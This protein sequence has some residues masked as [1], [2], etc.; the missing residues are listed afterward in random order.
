MGRNNLLPFLFNFY[1]IFFII[2]S[3]EFQFR[4]LQ[5]NSNHFGKVQAKTFQY[6]P[7]SLHIEKSKHDEHAPKTASGVASI[8]MVISKSKLPVDGHGI[9]ESVTE[10][11]D[12]LFSAN[13]GLISSS[14]NE[15]PSSVTISLDSNLESMPSKPFTFPQ[16]S[17][18]EGFHMLMENMVSD[19][20][21]TSDVPIY[22]IKFQYEGENKR[23]QVGRHEIQAIAQLSENGTES[24]QRNTQDALENSHFNAQTHLYKA[25]YVVEDVDECSFSR[26]HPWH[27]KCGRGSICVNTIGSYECICPQE[28]IGYSAMEVAFSSCSGVSSTEHCCN[29][30]GKDKD[31][32][33]SMFRCTND[34]CLGKCSKNAICVRKNDTMLSNLDDLGKTKRSLQYE[35]RC[36]KEPKRLIGSGYLCNSQQ[37]IPMVDRNGNLQGDLSEKDYCGCHDPRI[38]FCIGHSCDSTSEFCKS[39]EISQSNELGYEC[40]C[41]PG[42]A[43]IQD[44]KGINGRGSCHDSTKAYLSLNGNTTYRLTQGQRYYEKGYRLIDH[45]K[46]YVEDKRMYQVNIEGQYFSQT[47]VEDVGQFLIKYNLNMM[48]QDI[49]ETVYTA[50]R[51]LIVEDIDECNLEKSAPY[52]VGNEKWIPR[53]DKL[54]TCHNTINSYSCSC[55]RGT[56]GDGFTDL[57]ELASSI[58]IPPTYQGGSGCN[59]N[60]S[61]T[62]K[63]NPRSVTLPVASCELLH[64]IP[65]LGSFSSSLFN[66]SDDLWTKICH[67]RDYGLELDQ[68]LKEFP[69]FICPKAEFDGENCYEA[70]DEIGD[71]IIDYTRNIKIGSPTLLS[72]NKS[73]RS[74]TYTYKVPYDVSDLAGNAAVTQY[75]EVHVIEKPL[76]YWLT[77]TKTN[78]WDNE[79]RV[80]ELLE[81]EQIQQINE[82]QQEE[83]DK[84]PTSNSMSAVS[85]EA[86][87]DIM[88]KQPKN[89]NQ[90]LNDITSHENLVNQTKINFQN[91]NLDSDGK[92]NKQKDSMTR[93]KLPTENNRVKIESN[94]V[95][96]KIPYA[97]FFKFLF[98]IILIIAMLYSYRRLYI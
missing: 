17:A 91:K 29:D 11:D 27:H 93:R 45:N 5:T 38:D 84:F 90:D 92:P 49:T 71:N 82:L 70:W 6:V 7:P 42:Y 66:H 63:I 19:I 87:T 26:D 23:L 40:L 48:F 88:I 59:D 86:N 78:N 43:R 77:D 53:C 69:D 51:M 89:Q 54:A 44:G 37:P 21:A 47:E 98:S 55:P 24:L 39:T 13:A 20:Y 64:Q 1:I 30:T 8:S 16:D 33:K 76:D 3:G 56:S 35:C 52:L 18:E 10:K 9:Y 4:S 34:L 50:D 61:P 73:K 46:D 74:T 22:S 67:E 94:T 80:S 65:I 28:T 85:Q 96:S 2:N 81:H 58:R 62:L 12:T 95:P 36:P 25:I 41:K 32:C 68:I 75:R 83:G 72:T 97:W 31:E 14:M 57:Q 15:V 79:N 60:V